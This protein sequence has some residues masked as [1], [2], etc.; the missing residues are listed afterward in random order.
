MQSK[1]A[2][3]VKSEPGSKTYPPVKLEDVGKHIG[4]EVN[5]VATVADYKELGEIFLVNLG[6][7]YP[8]QQL[9]LLFKGEAKALGEKIKEK[10]TRIIV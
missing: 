5:I 10:G 4:E 7:P 3:V 2:P 6:A 9:T 1:P 8:N